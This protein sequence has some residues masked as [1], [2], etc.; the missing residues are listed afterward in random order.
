MIIKI[1]FDPASLKDDDEA[2]P[3]FK[4]GG[5]T[6]KFWA[7]YKKHFITSQHFRASLVRMAE[8]FE[9][10]LDIDDHEVLPYMNIDEFMVCLGAC[11]VHGTVVGPTRKEMSEWVVKYWSYFNPSTQ[12]AVTLQF[13]VVKEVDENLTICGPRPKPIP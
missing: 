8:M 10:M 5:I 11:G 2:W 6:L 1:G 9:R 4:A 7:L 13:K 3:A 12:W